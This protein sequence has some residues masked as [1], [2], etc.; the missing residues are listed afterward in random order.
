MLKGNSSGMRFSTLE[1][2]NQSFIHKAGGVCEYD[3]ERAG[4]DGRVV[5]RRRLS[6]C[7]EM[8][9]RPGI[10]V[11]GQ[12]TGGLLSESSGKH[13]LCAVLTTLP[14]IKPNGQTSSGRG[15]IPG[16]GRSPGKGNGSSLQ[17]SCLE[18]PMHR[19]A[20][21]AAVSPWVARVSGT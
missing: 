9:T 18:N 16:S 17:Y 4:F 20:W 7:V 13:I 15:S 10:E 2:K 6:S 14:N 11:M 19:R 12:D 3:S 8:H 5:L 21:K 1:M